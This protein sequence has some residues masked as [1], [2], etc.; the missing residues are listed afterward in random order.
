MAFHKMVSRTHYVLVGGLPIKFD[1]TEIVASP[2][3]QISC[4]GVTAFVETL[5]LISRLFSFFPQHFSQHAYDSQVFFKDNTS[6]CPNVGIVNRMA[7]FCEY[8]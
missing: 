6:K 4:T 5:Q 3:D 8:G 7:I 1:K 2:A